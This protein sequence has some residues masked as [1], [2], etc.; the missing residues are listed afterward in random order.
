MTKFKILVIDDEKSIREVFTV[1][2]E[3][4]GYR[5]E[6]A[7]TGAEG[8]ARARA[9]LPDI[10]L[11]DM[12][13]PDMTGLET[14]ARIKTALPQTDTSSSPPSGRSGTP[15]RRP[16]LVPTPTWRSRSI[17]TSCCSPSPG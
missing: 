15:S 14:L 5:V 4:K 2:L 13:L 12:N 6:S 16:S 11:L 8:I 10:V 3:E 9:F 17:T 1:L 7:G